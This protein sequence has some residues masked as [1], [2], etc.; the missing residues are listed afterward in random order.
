MPQTW[1]DLGGGGDDANA[2]TMP[3]A[4]QIET[5]MVAALASM[6]VNLR[7]DLHDTAT[8]RVLVVSGWNDSADTRRSI[9]R[10]LV[11]LRMCA[12]SAALAIRAELTD[13]DEGRLELQKNV[14]SII[15]DRPGTLTASEISTRRNPWI[16]E[17]LWHFCFAI[18]QNRTEVHPPG[19]VLAVHLPHPKV[20]DHGIDVAIIYRSANEFGISIVETKAYPE[21]VAG[22]VQNSLQFFR[23]VDRGEHAV[24]LRQMIATMRAALQSEEQRLVSQTLWQQRR[25]YIS[26]PHYEAQNAPDW[27]NERPALGGLVP[28]PGAVFIMPHEIADF[29]AF[30]ENIAEEM[31]AAVTEVL[32]H[33]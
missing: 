16:A 19:Q 26:N 17:G 5:W 8:H 28:G 12:I 31:R 14:H 32:T 30:F 9:A 23:E 15:G 29:D 3:L 21:N 2:L 4:Q 27:T 1:D 6:R 22:A 11:G 33:V 13:T 20:T 18:A 25:T 10:Y 24:R 7:V